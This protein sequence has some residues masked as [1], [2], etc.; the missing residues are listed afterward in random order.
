MVLCPR[1]STTRFR[2]TSRS[3]LARGCS[4]HC[5]PCRNSKSSQGCASRLPGRGVTSTYRRP[6][7]APSSTLPSMLQSPSTRSW[8]KE[9]VHPEG[10]ENRMALYMAPKTPPFGVHKGEGDGDA[11]GLVPGETAD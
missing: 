4:V 6:G 2:M 7:P 8:V 5:P 11:A 1:G 3:P 9:K 10:L